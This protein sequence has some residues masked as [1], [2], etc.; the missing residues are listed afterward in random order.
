MPASARGSSNFV[1][2]AIA[3]FEVD[4]DQFA[5]LSDCPILRG[6]AVLRMTRQDLPKAMTDTQ[7]TGAMI[8]I[9]A[10]AAFALR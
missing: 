9:Q 4:S 1:V 2:L 6:Y 5:K 3:V 7:V 10:R 8:T